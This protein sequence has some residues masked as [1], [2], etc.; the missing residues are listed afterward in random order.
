MQRS[1]SKQ[2]VWTF[3][4]YLRDIIL[5]SEHGEATDCFEHKW[6]DLLYSLNIRLKRRNYGEASQ[7][8]FAAL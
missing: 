6:Q 2:L 7:D 8:T 5:F 1:L 4:S 3:R